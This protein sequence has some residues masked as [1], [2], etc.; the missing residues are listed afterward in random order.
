[1]RSFQPSC[2]SASASVAPAPARTVDPKLVLE[3]TVVRLATLPPL[4][5]VDDILQRLEALAGG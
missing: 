2:A 5:P 1:V 3:M 4:L